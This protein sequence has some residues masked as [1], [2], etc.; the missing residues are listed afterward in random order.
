[1]SVRIRK[2]LNILSKSKSGDEFS[3]LIGKLRDNDPTTVEVIFEDVSFA[4]RL[5]TINQPLT[6]SINQT[7][8][9]NNLDISQ[10]YRL[11][12]SL[13]TNSTVTKLAL[14]VSASNLHLCQFV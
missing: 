2:S 5:F 1:M 13:R 8:E 3:Q 14:R 6:Q 12:E 11:I 10:H 9:Q 7:N 4:N